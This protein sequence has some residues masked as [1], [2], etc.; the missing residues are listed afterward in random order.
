MSDLKSISYKTEIRRLDSLKLFYVEIPF[1]VLTFFSDAETKNMYN[2]RLMISINHCDL[3]HGGVVSLGNQTGY[4]SIKGKILKDLGVHLDD[5]VDVYL[6]EDR[7]E[8]GMPFPEE[9]KEILAQNP[10]YEK[11]FYSLSMGK[12]RY[13]LY[14]VDQVKNVD[15]RIERAHFMLEKLMQN[16]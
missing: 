6:T 12:R 11:F 15:K 16:A 8:Y 4:I 3:W 13:V 5:E 9:V 7:S 1:D 10:S 14:Y 2:Q